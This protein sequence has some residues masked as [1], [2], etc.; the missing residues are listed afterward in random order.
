MASFLHHCYVIFSLCALFGAS[1]GYIQSVETEFAKLS[2]EECLLNV[3]S[4]SI[5]SG[6]VPG[7][8]LLTETRAFALVLAS[9]TTVVGAASSLNT[10]NGGRV[11][12]FAHGSFISG[13]TESNNLGK[14][15]LNLAKWVGKS[16][17]PKIA[18]QSGRS[19]LSDLVTSIFGGLSETPADI[20]DSQVINGELISSNFDILFAQSSHYDTDAEIYALRSFINEG[21][22]IIFYGTSWAFDYPNGFDYEFD[23]PANIVL[24]GTGINILGSI[25]WDY[26]YPPWVTPPL[27][28]DPLKNNAAYAL[29]VL[30]NHS[31]NDILTSLEEEY[32]TDTVVQALEELMD[33][34]ANLSSFFLSLE[35]LRNSVKSTRSL[36]YPSPDYTFDVESDSLSTFVVMVENGY[37]AYLPVGGLEAH[38]AHVDFPGAVPSSAAKLNDVQVT[39]RGV[40]EGL[41]T[42][43]VYAGAGKDLWTSTG[44]YHVAG[45]TLTVTIPSF[46]VSWGLSVRIGCHTDDLSSKSSLN[47][48]P[49]IS[50]SWELSKEVTSVGSAFGGLVYIVVPWGLNEGDIDVIISGAV[51]S[52]QYVH[53]VTSPDEWQQ[54]IGTASFGNVNV[55][56]YPPWGEFISDRYVLTLPTEVLLTVE[57]PFSVMNYWNQVMDAEDFLLG[58]PSLGWRGDR[59]RAE[60]MVVDVQISA[61]WM[62]SGYPFMAYQSV[63]SDMVDV[64][65][66]L[67]TGEWGPYHELGHNHQHDSFLVMDSTEVSCN[68]FS[69]FVQESVNGIPSSGT[70]SIGCEQEIREYLAAP[71]YE[72]ELAN[73]VWLHLNFF[74]IIKHAFGWGVIHSTL[75]SYTD[76]SDPTDYDSMTSTEKVD[77]LLYKLSLFSGHDLVNY[78]NAWDYPLSEEGKSAIHDLNLPDWDFDSYISEMEVMMNPRRECYTPSSERFTLVQFNDELLGNN[79]NMWYYTGYRGFVNVTENNHICQRWDS[80]TPNSHSYGP[81]DRKCEGTVGNNYCRTN[82]EERPWCYTV[83]GPRWEYCDVPVCD[84]MPLPMENNLPSCAE[85]KVVSGYLK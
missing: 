65:H 56:Q 78:A 26:N 70:D 49:Q 31:L 58:Y 51:K 69:A 38:P 27:F 40:Y 45:T 64:E 22:G 72:T 14:L 61:G 3:T 63:S 33:I 83:D 23:Y 7:S 67:E 32:A 66:L 46:A 57:D 75:R 84:K 81:D 42:N 34:S 60:R 4:V 76:G 74:L 17:D 13:V 20:T 8:I 29:D 21:G 50:R 6:S 25:D 73:D 24:S 18:L 82:G 30:K 85:F 10:I 2:Y 43:L 62:H 71:S 54:S 48:M 41:D 11:A 15:I 19:E 52:L 53:N 68:F 1:S 79:T 55:S 12:A 16:T 47:R 5:S 77:P 36:V 44:L 28:P 59:G 39:V 35:E 80:Q 37:A 9:E